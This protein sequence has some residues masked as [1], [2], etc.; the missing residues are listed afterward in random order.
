M[1]V[2]VMAGTRPEVIKMAPVIRRLKRSPHMRVT[3]CAT[4]QH[5]EILNRAFEDFSISPDVNLD[6]MSH[7][8]SLSH[9]SASLFDSLDNFLANVQPDWILI[10][11]DTTSVMVAALCAFY[12]HI[13]VGHVEAGLRS[14][15]LQAPFPEEL[16]RRIATLV[17]EAHFAP[18]EKARQNLLSEKVPDYK[19]LVTGNTVADALQQMIDE[20]QAAPNAA[21]PARLANLLNS[22]KR[23]V[24]LTAHR[25]EN[26]G[27]GL[28]NIF[29]AIRRFAGAYSDVNLIFPVHPNPA[30]RKVAKELLAGCD[31]VHLFDPFSYPVLLRAMAKSDF[32]ITDSGGIQEEACILRKP[33]LVLRETTERQEGVEAGAAKLLGC[34]GDAIMHWACRLAGDQGLREEMAM[35][36][37]SL[38]GDGTAAERI[39]AYLESRIKK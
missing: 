4:G 23:T 7:A 5:R 34:D 20:L 26:H 36:G 30:V 22:G 33:V 12:R 3:V 16:N 9:L 8:Q 17:T 39:A 19:I 1:D 25:R 24:L 38:Y 15:D 6:I 32:I 14:N 27:Q 21:L 13:N 35:A 2:V 31:N 28:E 11:G 18:T 29:S 37:G 10:Q